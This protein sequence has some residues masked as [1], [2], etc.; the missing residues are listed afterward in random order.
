MKI[1]VIGAGAMGCLYGARLLKAGCSVSLVD[2]W[3]P[4]VEAINNQGILLDGIEGEMR[5]KI[6]ATSD[7]ST[8]KDADLAII[9]VDANSTAVAGAAAVNMLTPDGVVLT[10]QN[11]IGNLEAL[12]AV[13]GR[14][15]VLGGLSFIAPSSRARDM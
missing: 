9:L 4:Q 8:L 6:D 3:K 11:G 7:P 14:D 2:V 10:L 12:D 13:L 5:V 1:C 15:R